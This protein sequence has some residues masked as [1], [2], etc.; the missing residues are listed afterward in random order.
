ML[1]NEW[2]SEKLLL[3]FNQG[4]KNCPAA[5]VVKLGP[6]KIIWLVALRP[7]W[8]YHFW[9]ICP[10][11]WYLSLVRHQSALMGLFSPSIQ[12]FNGIPSHY[13]SAGSNEMV[14]PNNDNN[15]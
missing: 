5:K 9:F 8:E 12:F 7:I 10:N 6:Q 2:T 3:C 14:N 4:Q 1:S 15:S 13:S 11:L